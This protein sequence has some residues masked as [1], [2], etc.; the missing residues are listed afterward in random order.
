MRSLHV[1]D[2]IMNWDGYDDLPV[3]ALLVEFR[4]PDI[5]IHGDWM[6]L[7]PLIVVQRCYARALIR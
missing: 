6:P 7:Y 3:V 1:Y 5:K 4:M 2:G